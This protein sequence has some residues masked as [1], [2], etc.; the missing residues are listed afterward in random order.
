LPSPI[1]HKVEQPSGMQLLTR[2]GNVGSI[3]NV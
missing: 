1:S 3:N 2:G